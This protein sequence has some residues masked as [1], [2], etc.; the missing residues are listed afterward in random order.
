MTT[1]RNTDILSVCHPALGALYFTLVIAFSMGLMNPVCLGISLVCAA[2]YLASLRGGAAI[3]KGFCY[4]LPMSLLAV[5]VSAAFNHA[6]GTTLRYLPS[7]NPLTLESILYGVGAALMLAA[8]LMWFSCCHAVMST[9][10]FVCLFGRVIPALSLVLSMSLRFVPRFAAQ[11]KAAAEAQ[12]ACGRDLSQGPLLSRLRHAAAVSSI[13]VTWSLDNAI[14]TADSMKS[15]GYGLPGRS[16][17]SI[18]RFEARDRALLAWLIFCGLYV[19]SGWAAGGLYFRYYPTV[20]WGAAGPLEASFYL[21]YL[22]LGLT[23]VILN[24]LEARKW[25]RFTSKA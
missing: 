8:A 17:F 3:K 6:G 12:R 7:G 14:E 16:A 15:R 1:T 20:K 9:D 23:P 2:L 10:K 5:A 21:C 25:R 24:Y 4:L 22:A 11:F 18:Y 19:A 13:V